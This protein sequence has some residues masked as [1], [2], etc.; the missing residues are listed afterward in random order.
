MLVTTTV[1]AVRDDGA[2]AMNSIELGSSFTFKAK[3]TP[4][5]APLFSLSIPL[6]EQVTIYL[7][8]PPGLISSLEKNTC[9]KNDDTHPPYFDIIQR[10]SHKHRSFTRLQFKLHSRGQLITPAGFV[11]GDYD[12]KARHTFAL[13]ASL[14]AASAFSLYLP[15]DV[16]TNASY[17]IFYQAWK[18]VSIPIDLRDMYNGTGGEL[19]TIEDQDCLLSS[20]PGAVVTTVATGPPSYNSLPKYSDEGKSPL[21]PPSQLST[22]S[23]SDTVAAPTPPGYGDENE[24]QLRDVKEYGN[25]HGLSSDSEGFNLHRDLKRRAV[26]GLPQSVVPSVGLGQVQRLI[27]AFEDRIQKVQEQ[28]E[29]LKAE[30]QM[31]KR[32]EIEQRRKFEARLEEQEEEIGRLQEQNE[33]LEER[34]I[35]TEG[36]E[37]DIEEAIETVDVHFD[38][39]RQDH[40]R[41]KE[42]LE[43]FEDM[44]KDY[45][46]DLAPEVC[47]PLYEKYLQD[48]ADNF[49]SGMKDSIRKALGD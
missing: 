44:M 14:A 27:D 4:P 24:G 33:A 45:M 37:E 30:V 22:T 19:Y 15:R 32:N 16:L 36:R 43:N 34:V 48:K 18:K 20:I 23:E 46:V 35:K 25:K 3:Y 2:V 21:L 6:T 47:K 31:G 17:Q 5:A 42:Q 39:M 12:A 29:S 8:F 11:L 9:N 41:L 38:E 7:R 26:D 13:V 40:E 49:M 10:H 28:M 1:V